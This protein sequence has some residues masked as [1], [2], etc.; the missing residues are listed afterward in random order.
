MRCADFGPTPGSRPSSSM[1]AWTGPSYS[2][3]GRSLLPRT[4]FDDLRAEIA[5]KREMESGGASGASTSSS[6]SIRPGRRSCRRCTSVCADA[7]ITAGAA[8]TIGRSASGASK[9]CGRNTKRGWN[10]SWSENADLIVSASLR[11]RPLIASKRARRH[12]EHDD[13]LLDA[14]RL[15][16]LHHRFQRRLQ[17][18]EHVRPRRDHVVGIHDRGQGRRALGL[19]LR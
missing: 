3:M 10:P 6:R 7:S 13:A 16:V 11:N 14:D 1:S 19:G 5:H 9:S 2:A 18:F 15:G 4:F 12:T 8:S 17:P